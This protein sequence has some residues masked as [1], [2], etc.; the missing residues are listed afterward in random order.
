MKIINPIDYGLSNLSKQAKYNIE[1]VLFNTCKIGS[2]DKS[3]AD[4]TVLDMSV[5][6]AIIRELSKLVPDLQHTHYVFKKF[7]HRHT[8][9]LS[10]KRLIDRTIQSL[11]PRDPRVDDASFN[12]EI[13]PN[14]VVMSFRWNLCPFARNWSIV[15]DSSMVFDGCKLINDYYQANVVDNSREIFTLPT[16]VLDKLITDSILLLTND[17]RAYWNSVITLAKAHTISTSTINTLITLMTMVGVRKGVPKFRVRV[18]RKD[19]ELEVLDT[20]NHGMSLED[21]VNTLLY[22]VGT[23]LNKQIAQQYSYLLKGYIS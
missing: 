20:L 17:I 23:L 15:G 1:D 5:P 16:D 2:F 18:I 3:L 7:S 22:L 19:L 14:L 9:I 12:L 11:C 4:L 13:T 10:R 6:D 8:F 21:Q